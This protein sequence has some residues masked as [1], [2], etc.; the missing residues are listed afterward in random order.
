[1]DWND[2]HQS[3][4]LAEVRRQLYASLERG[5]ADGPQAPL[6]APS[7]DPV[8]ELI[9]RKATQENVAVVYARKLKGKL[10]YAHT[11]NCWYEWAGTHWSREQTGKAFEY[12][13]RLSRRM[14]GDNKAGPAT[15]SF[16]D[17]VEKIVRADRAFATHG[18]EFD[19]DNYLLNTPDG[20]LDL[21]TNTV[22]S[23]DPEDMITKCTA[24][25]P[26]TKGGERFQNF[27][28]EVTGND[29]ELAHFLK[30]SLGACLSGALESHWMLFWIG[31][32]RNG[33]NTLGDLVAY[34]M[35]DYSK[36]I[37]SATLMAKAHESHP[38]DIASLQGVR[39]ATSSEVAGGARW[40]E[41]RIN[42]LT[43]DETL[44]ARFMRGDFF[45]FP[46]THKHLIYGNH[47][48]QLSSSTPALKSRIKIVPFSQSFEGRADP[49]LPE[50]LRQEAGYVLQ[51]LIDGHAEW[52]DNGRSLPLCAAVEAESD[53]Y[54]DAQGTVDSWIHERTSQVTDDGRSGRGWPK[55]SELYADYRK[56]KEARGEGAVSQTRWGEEVSAQF[57][58]VKAG[59]VR[60]VGVA[61]KPSWD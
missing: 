25:A 30:V 38:T 36:K 59:G 41:A 3:H 19:G 31:T 50:T 45:T 17:G 40:N 39:L 47:R 28:R 51:W 46:R 15:A 12:A 9:L 48:P 26:H 29:E 14:N 4:G 6:D 24:V 21:R 22:H 53:D 1:M 52:L 34:V 61:L 35:G 33:K 42:E 23:H 11:H 5:K 10:L 2:L 32:G 44:T 58:K 60:Y 8:D 43:G 49:T 37:P 55:S 57:K 56:W 27:I 20:T 54:F 13:R 7:C 16:Y 18:K